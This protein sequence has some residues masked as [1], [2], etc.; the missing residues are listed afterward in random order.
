MYSWI[1]V[2][3][4]MSS[5]DQVLTEIGDRPGE[6]VEKLQDSI[7]MILDELPEGVNWKIIQ[8]SRK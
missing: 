7:M 6:V 1:E 2:E 4:L 3:Y 8:S 5:G